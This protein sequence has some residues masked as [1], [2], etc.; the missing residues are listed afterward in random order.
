MSPPRSLS[1][2]SVVCGHE[3]PT[4]G[5]AADARAAA[6]TSDRGNEVLVP[7]VERCA[8]LIAARQ[9]FSEDASPSAC[10][11][12]SDCAGSIPNLPSGRNYTGVLAIGAVMVV[13]VALWCLSRRGAPLHKFYK[14]QR[15]ALFAGT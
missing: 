15:D 11:S 8:C 12:P 3:L 6:K 14:R 1:A 10:T 9:C 4:A 7:P 5:R 13:V 2:V